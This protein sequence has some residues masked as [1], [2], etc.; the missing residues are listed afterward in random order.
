MPRF[1][2]VGGLVTGI[3][4]LPHRN[5]LDAVEFSLRALEMPAVPTLPRRS[6]AEGSVAQALVGMGGVT[7]GQYGSISVDVGRIDADATVA[8]NLSH[9]AYLGVRTFLDHVP[10]VRPDLALVKWQF[11]GPVS[12]GV[13]LVRAGVPVAIAFDTAMRAVRG[14]VQ[15]IRDAIGTAL[16]SARQVVVLE[17]PTLAELMHPGFPIAPDVAIDLVSGALA[18]IEPAALTGLHVC[19]SVDVATQV[20]AGPGIL[21]LPVR[22]EV[23]ASAGYLVQFM[24][25]GGRIAWGAVPT[26]GPL[27]LSTERAW[28]DLCA[29]WAGLVERGAD[30][31]L[32]RRQSVITPECGLAAHTPIV[33]GRVF[34]VATELGRRVRGETT[35]ARWFLGA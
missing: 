34:E 9:D 1:E 32:L 24:E 16:P 3:G 25:R 8:T 21:S 18:V 29:V 35:P 17:E 12:L 7:I 5:A 2:L 14:H 10:T 28:R 23:V 11:I 31:A 26:S 4:G 30:P 15:H 19:G 20:A 6:P 13:S 27:A 33:A 22:K